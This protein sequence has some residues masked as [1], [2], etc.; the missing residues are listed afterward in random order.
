MIPNAWVSYKLTRKTVNMGKAKSAKTKT[1]NEDEQAIIDKE[2]MV[3]FVWLLKWMLI[4]YG[5]Y[6]LLAGLSNII[7]FIPHFDC[8]YGLSWEQQQAC[9]VKNGVK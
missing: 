4:W 3:W 7:D 1:A 5:V 6:L 9:Q 2:N 8:W